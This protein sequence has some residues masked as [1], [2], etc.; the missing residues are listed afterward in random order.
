MTDTDNEAGPSVTPPKK[1]RI[2]RY[3]VFN[4]EW[5]KNLEWTQWLRPSRIGKEEARCDICNTQFKIKYEGRGAIKAH[6]KSKHHLELVKAKSKN[7]MMKNFLI[8]KD[9]PE[10]ISVA[11]AEI[12]LTYHT[13]YHH[14]SYLSQDCSTKLQ[15]KF[16]RTLILQKK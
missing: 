7:H 15:K 4:D 16:T 3:C 6:A 9:T 8:Q 1:R 12:S 11:L 10:I 14:L 5:M 2:K 13:V